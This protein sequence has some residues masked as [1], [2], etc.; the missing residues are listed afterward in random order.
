MRQ[1]ITTLLLALIIVSVTVPVT[2]ASD[3]P[4]VWKLRAHVMDK[5]NDPVFIGTHQK[6]FLSKA[7]CEASVKEDDEIKND[8]PLLLKLPGAQYVAFECV[9]PRIGPSRD[10]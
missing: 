7:E 1:L 5:D 3:L 8:I 4:D 2:R 10:A 6:E 9:Q